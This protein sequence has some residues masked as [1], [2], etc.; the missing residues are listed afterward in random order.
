MNHCYRKGDLLQ[1]R[2]S[3]NKF[4]HL[5]GKPPIEEE[6]GLTSVFIEY[7]LVTNET[8]FMA[9]TGTFDHTFKHT[10]TE[11]EVID[12]I[13][14]DMEIEFIEIQNKS[15]D[16]ISDGKTV[17]FIDGFLPVEKGEDGRKYNREK[18]AIFNEYE[19]N[20]IGSTALVTLFVSIFMVFLG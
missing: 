2:S 6:N 14:E 19:S 5:S 7:K 13:L 20:V 4:T 11:S 10:L 12:L 3:S 16:Y 15:V 17:I 9:E 18:R 1:P 8:G